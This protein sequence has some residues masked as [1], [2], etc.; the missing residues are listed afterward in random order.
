MLGASVADIVKIFG[1][2]FLRLIGMAF[3]ISVPLAWYGVS[4]WLQGYSY[5]IDLSMEVFLLAG[6]LA[7]LIAMGTILFQSLKSG[8]L[9]PID[10]LRSE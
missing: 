8:R 5:R 2:D 3:I 10:T 1:A 6:V 4:Q 7:I 9:N